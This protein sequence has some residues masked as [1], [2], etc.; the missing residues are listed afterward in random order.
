MEDG[1]VQLM[2]L[3]GHHKKGVPELLLLHFNIFFYI[4]V[5]TACQSE[6]GDLSMHHPM[7]V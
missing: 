1:K 2:S 4:F 6:T 7:C 5:I 3:L